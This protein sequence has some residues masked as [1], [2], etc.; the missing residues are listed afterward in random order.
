[1]PDEQIAHPVVQHPALRNSEGKHIEATLTSDK[2][3]MALAVQHLLL[4]TLASG[5]IAGS[6]ADLRWEDHLPKACNHMNIENFHSCAI[7]IV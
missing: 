5:L 4:A 1:M 3:E 2:Q 7:Q 6:H